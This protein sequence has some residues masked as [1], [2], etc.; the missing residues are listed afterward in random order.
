[1]IY[2]FYLMHYV[3]SFKELAF[4]S[5]LSEIMIRNCFIREIMESLIGMT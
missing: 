4:S 3:K 1:M 5:K 2:E